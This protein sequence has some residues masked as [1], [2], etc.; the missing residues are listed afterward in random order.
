VSIES[1]NAEILQPLREGKR[2][3]AFTALVAAY[4][5]KLHHLCV[6]YMREPARAEDALQESLIRIWRFLPQY[7]GRASLYTWIYRLT[8]NQCCTELKRQPRFEP[9]PEEGEDSSG[10]D[11]FCNEADPEAIA[12]QRSDNEQ[13]RAMVDRLPERSRR[14][15]VL[16]HYED[17]SVHEVAKMLG[18][19]ET[20]VRTHLYRARAALHDQLRRRGFRRT[21]Q[22]VEATR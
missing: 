4:R 5:D 19:P 14:V 7:D 17:R 6:A 15:L 8:R 13:L 12:V 21:E 9:I 2:D 3:A 1:D 22:G 20:T 11:L 18:M 16:F 10:T